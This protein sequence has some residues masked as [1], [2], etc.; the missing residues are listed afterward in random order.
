MTWIKDAEEEGRKY[1][2]AERIQSELAK[3]QD[4]KF[5]QQRKK[6]GE[7]ELKEQVLPTTNRHFQ[8]H[9]G[10]ILKELQAAGYHCDFNTNYTLT[11]VQIT[12]PS[13]R[14]FV[15]FGAPFEITINDEGGTWTTSEMRYLTLTVNIRHL[16][17]LTCTPV[18]HANHQLAGEIVV[19]Q[20]GNS[21]G[22]E[23]IEENDT[24]FRVKKKFQQDLANIIRSI[25]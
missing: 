1:K 15:L 5:Q 17:T 7:I 19:W 6:Q 16:G 11:R 3:E 10:Q 14:H 2:E 8:K 24:S 21:K 18:F 22:S 13:A 25:S 20:I 23:L 4:L 9:F 12:H